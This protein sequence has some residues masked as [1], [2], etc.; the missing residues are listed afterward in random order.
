[1][2]HNQG[3]GHGIIAHHLLADTVRETKP[4]NYTLINTKEKKWQNVNS[5]FF[6]FYLLSSSPE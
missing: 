3:N 5:P 6:D 1:M 4:L 2:A